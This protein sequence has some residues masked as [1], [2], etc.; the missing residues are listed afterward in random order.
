MSIYN[1]QDK[2]ILVS[3][4]NKI[5]YSSEWSLT[6][7]ICWGRSLPIDQWDKPQH[8]A[9]PHALPCPWNVHLP[10]LLP[11][12]APWTWPWNRDVS[13]R[14]SGWYTRL[15]SLK[16]T[17]STLKICRGHAESTCLAATQD[18][19]KFL[20]LINCHLSIRDGLPL[21]SVSLLSGCLEANVGLHR[22]SPWGCELTA[23]V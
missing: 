9:A 6:K 17:R 10:C 15:N 11:D 5:L 13:L 2:Y 8:L 23:S 22:E 19:C 16:T 4:C 1:T 12:A 7:C 14:P 3:S 18:I 20:A 21:S